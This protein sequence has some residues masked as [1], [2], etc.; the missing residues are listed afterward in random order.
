MAGILII[1]IRWAVVLTLLYPAYRLLLRND[2]FHSMNRALLVTILVLSFLLPFGSFLK[3]PTGNVVS[4]ERCL[5]EMKFGHMLNPEDRFLPEKLWYQDG[6]SMKEVKAT[7]AVNITYSIVSVLITLYIIG[8][9]I[10]WMLLFFQLAS[11]EE[12]IL[13]SRRTEMESVPGDVRLMV[14]PEIRSPFSWMRW[15]FINEIDLDNRVMLEHELSHVRMRHSWD[16]LLC[17]ITCRMLWWLPFAW[18]LRQDLRDVHEFQA[19]QCVLSCGVDEDEY[20]LLMVNKIVDAKTY[21]VVNTFGQSRIKRRIL[22]M[23]KEASPK[24]TILKALYI[25]P[26][27]LFALMIFANPDFIGPVTHREIMLSQNKGIDTNITTTLPS[28]KRLDEIMASLRNSYPERFLLLVFYDLDG[29][30]Y[31]KSFQHYLESS[32]WVRSVLAGRNDAKVVFVLGAFVA[33]RKESVKFLKDWS[34]GEEVV[35]LSD[36]EFRKLKEVLAFDGSPHY[37]TITPEGLR[38]KDDYCVN[39]FTYNPYVVK[40]QLDYVINILCKKKSLRAKVHEYDKK[41]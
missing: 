13:R 22:M 33:Y 14:N 11:L 28:E 39:S 38:L 16:M 5:A 29:M 15:I 36:E 4:R 40:N 1:I 27:S 2:T 8:L 25:L 24:W 26:L 32:Q 18:M 30:R 37:E 7:P 19:D 20:Q 3:M 10:S 17:E 6:I 21:P 31:E 12:L 9:V 35:S 34:Y 23:C 41:I